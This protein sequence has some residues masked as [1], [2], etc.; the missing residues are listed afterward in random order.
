MPNICTSTNF[1]KCLSTKTSNQF[2]I[3]LSHKVVP[4]YTLVYYTDTKST[5]ILRYNQGRIREDGV[6]PPPATP[7]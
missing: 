6:A 1:L 3:V 4:A 7:I 2:K 5:E